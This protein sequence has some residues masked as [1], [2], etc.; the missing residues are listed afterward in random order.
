MP[1][2]IQAKRQQLLNV[3]EEM[4]IAAGH[5]IA[6]AR[7]DVGARRDAALFG[8]APSRFLVAVRDAAAAASL[9]ELAAIADVSVVDI[10]RVGGET[11]ALGPIVVSLDSA[12]VEWE[13]GLDRALAEG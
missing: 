3:V 4:C 5:G 1:P 10:G 11:I 7:I 2:R 6:A 12:R 8:E 9:L 13:S